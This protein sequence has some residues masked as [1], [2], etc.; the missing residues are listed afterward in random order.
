LVRARRE[1]EAPLELRAVARVI[2]DALGDPRPFDPWRLDARDP[3]TV[4]A[5]LP[6]FEAIATR[7][8]RAR[9]EGLENLTRRPALYV[10][11]HSGGIMGP[12]LFCTLSALWRTLGAEAPLYALAHDFAMRRVTP[13]GRVL[14]RV[15]ALRAHPESAR[16]A[17]R[18]GGSVLVYPGGDL[19]AYRAFWKRDRIVFGSRAG[20]VR[21]AQELGVP[22]LPIVAQGAH[23]SALIVHEGEWL[24]GVLGLRRWSR[25]ER[26]PL[27]L[28]LP[29]IVG[30]GPW[31][32][33][34]PL[35]FQVRVRVL[36][37]VGVLRGA[38]PRVVQAQIVSQMQSALSDLALRA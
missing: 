1:A 30:A 15:G 6:L 37:A 3:A 22:I 8:L 25:I 26:F 10:G 21:V 28:S 2:A 5:L 16:R 24:A 31:V 13:L 12:D 35:P 32:P 27:A 14:Q 19:D 23:R 17:L 4:R 18:A 36:P 33:Y 34:L 11:N 38:D 7:Y 20:F 29:W 9:I